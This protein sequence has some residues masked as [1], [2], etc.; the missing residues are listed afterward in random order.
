MVCQFYIFA[1]RSTSN[2]LSVYGE[3]D[4]CI[5]IYVYISI[6]GIRRASAADIETSPRHRTQGR[7]ETT[8]CGRPFPQ[9]H[10]SCRRHSQPRLPRCSHGHHAIS[11]RA[12]YLATN[13][14]GLVCLT[15]LPLLT[16]LAR[17]PTGADA[18]AE[19]CGGGLGLE[20]SACSCAPT[21]GL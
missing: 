16:P 18:R 10:R 9:N 7:H 3:E 8:F 15:S 11:S 14:R 13:G 20:Q 1:A 12:L 19:N 4:T 2:T 6:G 21:L 17:T 5:C